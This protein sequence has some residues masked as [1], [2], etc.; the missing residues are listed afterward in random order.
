LK[1]EALGRTLWRTHLGRG[2]GLA[3]RQTT[4]WT[5]S[6]MRLAKGRTAVSG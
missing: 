2:C 1:D 6:M 3:V 5:K 4:E